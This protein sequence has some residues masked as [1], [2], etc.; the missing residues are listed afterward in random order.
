MSLKSSRIKDILIS[1]VTHE[2]ESE[3]ILIK[4]TIFFTLIPLRLKLVMF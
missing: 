1:Q 4:V 2:I 3:H